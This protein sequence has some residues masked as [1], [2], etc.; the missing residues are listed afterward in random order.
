MLL[1]AG[2]Y[3]VDELLLRLRVGHDLLVV[4]VQPPQVVLI[5]FKG[6]LRGCPVDP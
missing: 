3:L 1:G 6:L 4:E 5:L 2:S